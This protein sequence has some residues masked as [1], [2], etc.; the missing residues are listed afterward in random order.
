MQTFMFVLLQTMQADI[1]ECLVGII[2]Y[3]LDR[4]YIKVS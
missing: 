1:L 3:M 2:A 4:D